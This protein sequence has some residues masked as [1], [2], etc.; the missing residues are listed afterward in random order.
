MHTDASR[1]GQPLVSVIV[2]TV[3]RPSLERTLASLAAQRAR[4]STVVPRASSSFARR[5]A[6]RRALD[7]PVRIGG[8][9]TL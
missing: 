3:L 1:T 7:G 5:S 8:N 4:R 9:A 2:P 6:R